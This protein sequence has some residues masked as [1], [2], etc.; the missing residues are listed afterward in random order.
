MT[1]KQ[2]INKYGTF[3]CDLPVGS[4]TKHNHFIE[5]KNKIQVTKQLIRTTNWSHIRIVQ[6]KQNLKEL[7]NHNNLNG[8]SLESFR[9]CCI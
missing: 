7:S 2:L 1:P 5:L 6:S 3:M 9:I 4:K 8:N